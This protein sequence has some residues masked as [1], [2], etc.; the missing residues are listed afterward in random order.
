MSLEVT[1]LGDRY[2]AVISGTVDDFL[3]HFAA[4]AVYYHTL[5]GRS[6]VGFDEIR[7]ALAT[8]RSCF[9]DAE[10]TEIRVEENAAQIKDVRHAAQ[11]FVVRF[12]IEGAYVN[13]L[14]GFT[15]LA[16][17]DGQI[18]SLVLTHN[19]WLNTAGQIMRIEETFDVDAFRESLNETKGNTEE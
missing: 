6:E 12:T 11:C 3:K 2:R 10:L 4:A 1:E 16:H 7:E 9:H 13:P 17:A 15:S 5:L 18:G 19:V 14:P 8:W